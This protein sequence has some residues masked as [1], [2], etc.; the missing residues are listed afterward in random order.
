MSLQLPALPRGLT[1]G[2]LITA[3]NDRLRRISD[4]LVPSKLGVDGKPGAAGAAGAPG[5]TGGPTLYG[6]HGERLGRP[7]PADATMFVE[8][9]RNGLLYQVR[10]TGWAF[11]SGRMRGAWADLPAGL[12][13]ADTGLEYF[14]AVDSLHIWQWTGAAWDWGPGDRH[15]GEFGQF[16]AD[17]GVGWH[18]CDGAINQT[19]YAADGTRVTNFTVPDQREFYLQASATYTGVGVPAAAPGLTGSTASG[20][21]SITP[22]NTAGGAANL[23]IGNTG[24]DSG[25]GQAV[26][27]GAGT[28]VAAHTHI[29]PGPS[30]TDLG[31]VHLV[32][33]VDAGHIHGKGTLAVDATATPATFAVLP[34]YRL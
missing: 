27:S 1:G 20:A 30:V 28:T 15:S 31:H 24:T 16:D 19:R 34:Y 25:G 3:L 9:D 14:D 12:G 7:V 18:L 29:H 6:T 11:V 17:P 10:G 26:Q 8:T 21:A 22:L 2:A 23:S 5:T 4:A 13:S 32:S 33:P